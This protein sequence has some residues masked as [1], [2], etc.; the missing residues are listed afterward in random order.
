MI[1]TR[2]LLVVCI[3]AGVILGACGTHGAAHSSGSVTSSTASTAAGAVTSPTWKGSVAAN[4]VPLG[5]GKVST[6]PRVGFID[7]CIT[8]FRAGGAQHAGSWLDTASGTWNPATKPSVQGSVDWPSA[9]NSFTIQGDTRVITSNGLPKGKSTGAFPIA[10]SDPAYQYD[11]NPNK[12]Q[13]QSFN[14]SVPATPVPAASQTCLGLGV[15]G[16]MTD[17]VALFDALD[18]GGHDAGAHEIQDSCDGHP[19]MRGI[20]HY[21]NAS[22]CLLEDATGSS[23]LIGYALDGFGIYVERDASGQLPT[24]AD[25]DECHGRT[26]T[27]MWDGKSTSTY[28]YDV[29][30]EYPYTLGCYRGTPVSR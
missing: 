29:T 5:D 17:G 26:S 9:S 8:N 4:A 16:V 25:L 12:I 1:H 20:Y 18:D 27:V 15:I 23:M 3:A 28:H 6:T 2:H 10:T 7:S 13:E 30:A 24:D 19:Q 14:Y 22:K 21:H 11:R